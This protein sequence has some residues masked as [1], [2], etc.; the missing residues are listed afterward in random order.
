MTKIFL[1]KY[2]FLL[3]YRNKSYI[4]EPYDDIIL[5]ILEFYE[6]SN[7]QTKKVEKNIIKQKIEEK[8]EDP[9]DSFLSRINRLKNQ[10][11]F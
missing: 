5:R 1:H 7:P 9:Y 3:L 4:N 11:N 8:V 6:E 10:V 2:T